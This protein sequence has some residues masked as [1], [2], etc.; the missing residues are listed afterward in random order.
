M[1]RVS[2]HD[3]DAKDSWDDFWRRAVD[4]TYPFFLTDPP[5]AATLQRRAAE[6]HEEA[7][8]ARLMES[9]IADM[10]ETYFEDPRIRAALVKVGEVGDPWLPGSALTET[11]FHFTTPLRQALPIGG[12]GAITQTMARAAQEAGVTIRTDSE[13]DRILVDDERSVR[14]VRLASGEELGADLVLSNAD[15]TRTYLRLLEPGV[16]SDEFTRQVSALSTATS[17]LKMHCVLDHLPDVSRYLGPDP[18]PRELGYMH[19]APSLE[20]FRDAHADAIAGTP[21]SRPVVHIQLPTVYDTSIRDGDG[22]MA[23]IWAMY[24]P[25][26]LRE[27]TW[28]GRRQQVGEALLAYIDEFIP[29][30]SRIVRTWM[31]LTPADMEERLGLTRGNI[32]HLDMRPGQFL[33]DRPFPGAGYGTPVEGLYLCGA[34]THPGGEVTGAPGHNAAHAVLRSRFPEMSI[35]Q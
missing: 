30:F 35:P 29:G 32:R 19:I 31:L 3:A 23:S 27:G 26:V 22:H 10:C 24:A 28:D 17:Y 2:P 20:T 16:L 34:G 7:T 25:P 18:D 14:G 11:Y 21:A 4:I 8:L 15:P 13:V 33:G 1:A 12:M 9:S 5:D 6:I